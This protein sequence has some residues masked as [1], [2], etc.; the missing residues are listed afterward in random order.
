MKSCRNTEHKADFLVTEQYTVLQK[1]FSPCVLVLRGIWMLVLFCFSFSFL[2]V[3]ACTHWEADGSVF[4]FSAVDH[5]KQIWNRNRE[6]AGIVGSLY[7][8][9]NNVFKAKEQVT[10]HSGLHSILWRNVVLHS[11]FT[12]L[13]LF[14]N[15]QI[16][17][18]HNKIGVVNSHKIFWQTVGWETYSLV[19]LW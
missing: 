1:L 18:Y 6:S 8:S 15:I 3:G 9:H 10:E 12:F 4:T 16:T 5:I 13:S 17:F 14:Q 2:L 11:N 19:P 7:F